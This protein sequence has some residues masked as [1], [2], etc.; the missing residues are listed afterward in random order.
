MARH[1]ETGAVPGLVTVL[2]TKDEVLVDAI[3]P[4][5]RD[6]IFRITSLTKPVTAAAAL[7]LVQDG[8]VA[9]DDPVAELLPELAE[10]RVL[11]SP[12]A[13]LTDT[14]AAQRPITVR[15]LLTFCWG[16]GVDPE[17][18]AV[19]PVQR[20]IEEAELAAGPP[21]PPSPHSPDEWMRRLGALPL[22]RQP[23]EK[24]IYH[25]GSDVLGVLVAR[26]SGTDLGSFLRDRILDPLG[27]TDTGFHVPTE[28]LHRL[29]PLHADDGG[30][31]DPPDGAW[32]RPPAFPSGGGGLV[33]TPD[34]VMAFARMITS[35]GG[36]LLTPGS[37][38]L[39]TTD[40]LIPTQRGSVLLG[41]RG[42]GLGMSVYGPADHRLVGWA[43]GSGTY[44]FSEPA[45]G[46]TALL[47]TQRM[48]GS[49][50]AALIDDF[51]EAAT[52]SLL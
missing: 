45:R 25:V 23:G 1:V 15:D 12:D 22:M 34:D 36:E 41:D 11:T 9:L 8:V 40:Q 52:A 31:L 17:L 30:V 20:A 27:M 5:R 39:M 48:F 38:E 50:S 29:P 37:V 19:A 43:G 32:S 3:A 47:F 21:V 4:M 18:A 16:L 7:L 26:A 33:S 6:T 49:G 44:W 10:P 13:P 51:E 28:Q 14:V 35:G 46:T 42:W 24:W 2:A